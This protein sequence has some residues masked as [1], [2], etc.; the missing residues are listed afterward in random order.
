MTKTVPVSDSLN[1]WMAAEQEALRVGI[2]PQPKGSMTVDQYAEKTNRSPARARFVLGSMCKTGHAKSE[3][4]RDGVS[5]V[6][7]VYWLN[8]K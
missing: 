1:D 6:R 8:K 3:K 7:K 2:L 4:W 5:G